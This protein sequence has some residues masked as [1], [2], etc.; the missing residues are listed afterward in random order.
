MTSWR[1]DVQKKS[2]IVSTWFLNVSPNDE[3]QRWGPSV[4]L[5]IST[6]CPLCVCLQVCECISMCFVCAF[7]SCVCMCA[8]LFWVPK[9]MPLTRFELLLGSNCRRI[10]GYEHLML[11]SKSFAYDSRGSCLLMQ[12]LSATKAMCQSP[13]LCGNHMFA[14]L[15][16]PPDLTR[17]SAALILPIL[18]FSILHYCSV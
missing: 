17:I 3:T 12:S 15:F 6:P 13:S 11:M 10:Q 8:G 2:G 5:H 7:P 9:H 1:Q 14:L 18:P 4:S 16:S